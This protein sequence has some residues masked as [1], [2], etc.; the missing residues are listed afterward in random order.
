MA[1]PTPKAEDVIGMTAEELKNKL[2]ATVTKED[3][4]NSLKPVADLQGSIAAIQESLKALTV[5]PKKETPPE[6]NDDGV[7]PAVRVLTD[8]EKFLK[9]GTKDIREGQLQTQADLNEMR[10][11]QD[12]RFSKLFGKYGK[13]L[14]ESAA[15]VPLASRAHPGFWEFHV[16][17]FVGDLAIQG[18]ITSESYPTLLG[19]SSTGPSDDDPDNK[20]GNFGFSNDMAEFFRGRGK[21]LG[22]MAFLRDRMS[23]DG[24]VI[25]LSTW[26][27]KPNAA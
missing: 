21:D 17:Q 5:P 1:W 16:R 14:T 7:D 10:A 27:K 13:E 24:D 18:K 19:T 22:K 2:E 11:R 20:D 15:K 12:S 6:N 25:D 9:D 8:P 23:R 26:K 4:E 3:L